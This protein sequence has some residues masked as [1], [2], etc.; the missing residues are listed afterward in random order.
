VQQTLDRLG[1]PQ[2]M[3]YVP[4]GPFIHGRLNAEF[5]ALES[6][7]LAEV[8]Q[9]KAF[10]IDSFEYPNLHNGTPEFKVTYEEATQKCADHG[11]RLCT[12]LEWEKA[13]KGPRNVI[14]SYGDTFDEEFCGNGFETIYLSGSKANCKS[15][16]Q[17]FDMSGN[18]REWTSTAP[19][20]N[21][22]DR[23]IVKG[24]LQNNPQ[25]GTRCAFLT[26]E[27][28]DYAGNALSFRCCRDADINAMPPP[29]QPVQDA[30]TEDEET[31][32]SE[33]E[34]TPEGDEAPAEDSPAEDA[35]GEP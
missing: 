34:E 1:K 28:K 15:G 24:G 4:A 35:P 29:S 33:D 13:C 25:R 26:D 19:K 14:Y 21:K 7:E 23:R 22:D 27:R 31:P 32:E 17:V 2:N 12:E 16:W 9:M 10:L 5:D 11:K 8:T 20:S 30:E 3:T 18:F 6:E